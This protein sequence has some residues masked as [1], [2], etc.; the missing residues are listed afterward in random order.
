M[1]GRRTRQVWRHYW[2]YVAPINRPI[3]N[4]DFLAI[5]PV[6]DAWTEMLHKG[7]AV[8][9]NLEAKAPFEVEIGVRGLTHL[10]WPNQHGALTALKD[11]F[12]DTRTASAWDE[13]EKQ[14]FLSKCRAGLA[15]VYGLPPSRFPG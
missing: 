14:G 7:L 3:E 5:T 11:A 12:S 4:S 8:L 1:V 6:S 15:D 2:A 9:R 10:H 13:K